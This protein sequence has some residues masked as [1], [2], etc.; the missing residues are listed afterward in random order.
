MGAAWIAIVTARLSQHDDPVPW[1]SPKLGQA[2]TMRWLTPEEVDLTLADP[3]VADP[4]VVEDPGVADPS[5]VC[6]VA[7]I[8]IS[9]PGGDPTMFEA[10]WKKMSERSAV[11]LAGSQSLSYNSDTKN[12]SW[13]LEPKLEQEIRRLHAIVSNVAVEEDDHYY[14][15]VGTGSSQLIQ[16]AF[17][18]LS[19]PPDAGD[20][21]TTVVCAAPY[22]S[23]YPEITDLVR[24]RCFKWGGDARS[25]ERDDEPFIEL[26]TTPNN[27]DGAIRE[28]VVN[29][30]HQGKVVYDLAYYWPHFTPITS[31]ANHDLML[32]TISKCTGHAGSRIGWALVRDKE[33]AKKMIKFVDV[34]TIGVSKDS[35]LRAAKILETVS[36][37]C[38]T[39]AD[40]ENF[41]VFSRNILKERWNRLRELV[42]V[43]DL[44]TLLKYPIQYCRF[45]K[46][47]A[48]TIPAFGWIESKGEEDCAELLKKHKILGRC[49]TKFGVGKQFAR[50]SLVSKDEEFNLLLQRLSIIQGTDLNH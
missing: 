49:G 28:P 36:D 23:A 12:L 13:Y 35:Q 44:F 6:P 15:V 48:D 16:A 47:M 34:S 46:D 38:S 18:A 43:A 11:T 9:G 42:K 25:F 5:M 22:Y 27:P 26:V 37:S 21:P 8:V 14:I 50:I 40:I 1:L 10:Y 24:S 39:A 3:K 32:F 45:A 4:E 30:P 33:V 20:R 17:Y 29:R 7:C 41:F 19:Q 2:R 31:P